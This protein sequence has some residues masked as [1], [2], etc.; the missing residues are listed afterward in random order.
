MTIFLFKPPDPFP[1]FKMSPKRP[2]SDC[3][4]N[5][6]GDSAGG[7]KSKLKLKKKKRE[8]QTESILAGVVGPGGGGEEIAK[9]AEVDK[10]RNRVDGT[11]KESD[12]A[13]TSQERQRKEDKLDKLKNGEF[14]M[15]PIGHR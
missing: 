4:S 8:K 11:N 10:T 1:Y 3:D 14:E 13:D 9:S 7:R 12:T 6:S 15:S 5:I 2:L